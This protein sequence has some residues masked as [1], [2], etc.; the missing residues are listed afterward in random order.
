EKTRIDNN[1]ERNEKCLNLLTKL[2]INSKTAGRV[3]SLVEILFLIG[4]IRF[5]QGEV[6]EAIDCL[7]KCFSMAEPGGYMRIFL[8][9]GE[10]LRALLSAY[11]QKSNPVH[12]SFVLKI[13]K[14]LDGSSFVGKP[15]SELQKLITSR[16]KEV[17]LLIAEGY[18]NKQIAEKLV[19][20]EGTVK[21]H[22]HN[23]LEKLQADNRTRIIV[24]AKDLNLI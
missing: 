20:S 8:D 17:L 13:I 21:F 1:S 14:A 23:L 18:S 19:L 11:L 24:R 5:S 3:N 22:V 12:K 15:Q 2:E 9:T 4:Y 6:D 16:E 7:D 10:P